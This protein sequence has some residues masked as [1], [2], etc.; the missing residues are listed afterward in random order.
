VRAL[1]IV[2]VQ[3]DFSEGG[4]LA[5]TGGASVAQAISRHLAGPDAGRYDY[6]V[7]TQDHHIDPGPHFSA[8]PDFVDSWPPHC[9]AGTSGAEFNPDLDVSRIA[10]VF[11]KGERAAAYSGF[12]GSSAAGESLP[13]WLTGRNVT[14]VD[15]TGLATDYCV[16]ATATDAATAGFATTVLLDLTAGVSEA[17][18]AAALATMRAAGI[19]LTGAPRTR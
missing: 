9:V 6:V 15:I 1:L 10:E 4:S 17:T 5:V 2:D 19:T 7:A 3:N 18:T 11:R 8:E 12:E 14:E 16:R 13:A